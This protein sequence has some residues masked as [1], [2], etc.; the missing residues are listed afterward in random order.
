MAKHAKPKNLKI[1]LLIAAVALM[2]LVS[3]TGTVAYL[4]SISSPADNVFTP[5][6][7]SCQVEEAA[8]NETT[9][10]VTVKNTGNTTAF[11]RVAVIANRT[12][13]QGGIYSV[14]PQLGTDYN[15]TL[16]S[17]WMTG[18]DG[19]YYYTKAVSPNTSTASALTIVTS[20][21]QNFEGYE[22]SINLLASAVQSEPETTPEEA[23]NT[24]VNGN[25]ML[26]K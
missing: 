16:G 19:F 5:A 3:V 11:I 25:T 22:L 15:I 8:E 1:K 23:W 9:K 20:D 18:S 26:P 14:A 12:D 4:V 21:T 13:S 2:L 10:T 6:K 24:E 7:V 17:D